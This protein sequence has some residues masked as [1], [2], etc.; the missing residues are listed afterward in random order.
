MNIEIDKYFSPNMA[1]NIEGDTET[2]ADVCGICLE[3]CKDPINRDPCNHRFCKTCLDTWYQHDI[4]HSCPLCR[5][6]HRNDPPEADA[7]L[8]AAI[9]VIR[10][11]ILDESL[12]AA[13]LM[14]DDM[15]QTR[16]EWLR[17][18]NERLSASSTNYR[19]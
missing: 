1:F 12:V 11:I 15:I 2:T 3:D 6:G 5:D 16:V 7:D 19:N 17:M 8:V 18:R 10:D 13:N 4:H 9:N 14:L